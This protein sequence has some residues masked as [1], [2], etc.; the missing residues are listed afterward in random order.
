MAALGALAA[1]IVVFATRHDP[2]L[3]PDSIT[4]LSVARHLRSGEG[5]TD[6]TGDPLTIFPPLYS[7][8]LAPG[9]TSLVWVRV[10]SAVLAAA[11]AVLLFWLLRHRVGRPVAIGAT[12]AFS[13]S[14]GIVMISSFAWSELPALVLALA[15]LVVLADRDRLTA[16]W[17]VVA[18]VLAGMTFLT[19]YAGAGAIAAG[20]TVIVVAAWPG[21]RSRAIRLVG[22]FTTAVV[23]VC[24]V[25]VIRNLVVVGQPLGPRFEGG[26]TESFDVLIRRPFR[27]I[28][29]LVLGDDVEGEFALRTGLVV[30]ALIVVGGAVFTRRDRRPID[31]GV[32]VFAA[33]AFLLPVVARLA[34]SNDISP[35]VMA[36]VLLPLV[37]F[38]AVGTEGLLS[39]AKSPRRWV[40][41]CGVGVASFVVAA[42]VWQGATYA[43]TFPDLASS[44]SRRLYSP[45]LFDA[46]DELDPDATVI[47]NNPW[48]VFWVNRRDPVLFG[49][50]LPRSGNSHYPISADR[51]ARLACGGPT[52]LAWFPTFLR[53]GEVPRERLQDRFGLFDLV[54]LRSVRKMAGGELSRVVPIGDACT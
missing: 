20:G 10:V 4:Y 52:Y 9:G 34:T 45:E 15:V 37:Y 54:E 31:A 3:S 2:R 28:G 8:L 38:A 42:V 30:S 35:R 14:R 13:F 25:W 6:F 22:L 26:T 39:L 36:P 32:M 7:M 12:I 44:G 1:A 43:S 23:A 51:I 27:S 40:G 50:V 33:A 29:Q 11:S 19:R 18:G 21:G 53:A 17:C 41:R 48:S 16:R 5:I 46:I 24:A 49:F 47:T